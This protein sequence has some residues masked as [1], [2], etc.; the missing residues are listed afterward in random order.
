MK[1]GVGIVMACALSCCILLGTLYFRRSQ[2]G[3]LRGRVLQLQDELQMSQEFSQEVLR[4]LSTATERK[5]RMQRSLKELESQVSTWEKELEERRRQTGTC[6][7]EQKDADEQLK[8]SEKELQDA[9]SQHEEDKAGWNNDINSLKKQVEL[10]S[11]VCDYVDKKSA[12]GRKLCGLP[13]LP[14][15]DQS[16]QETTGKQQ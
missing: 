9:K 15:A 2:A 8:S 14:K 13:E 5:N 12:E 7:Q 11:K 16:Q 10:K 3:G 6:Q 1:L 4:E